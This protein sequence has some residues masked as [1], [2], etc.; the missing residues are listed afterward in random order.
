MFTKTTIV[1]LG[2]FV[3]CEVCTLIVFCYQRTVRKLA[4]RLQIA[5]SKL[6]FCYPKWMLTMYKGT[7]LKFGIILALFII[8]WRCALVSLGI[9]ALFFFLSCVIIVPDGGNLIRIRREVKRCGRGTI[10]ITTYQAL[11]TE[12]EKGIVAT[13]G[14][15]AKIDAEEQKQ[16][17]WGLPSRQQENFEWADGKTKVI[18]K[19]KPQDAIVRTWEN[20]PA[21]IKGAV[22]AIGLVFGG[23]LLLVGVTTGEITPLLVL[24]LLFIFAWLGFWIYQILRGKNWTRVFAI[25]IVLQVIVSSIN[26]SKGGAFDFSST[27]GGACIALVIAALLFCP[28]ANQWFV[29]WPQGWSYWP[30]LLVIAQIVTVLINQ[31]TFERSDANSIDES[32]VSQE[33]RHKRRTKHADTD[34]NINYANAP[35]EK[36]QE[37]AQDGIA[38]AQVNL[39]LRYA[40]GRGG[41]EKDRSTSFKWYL[42]AADQGNT[43][44]M[45]RVVE[46]YRYGIGVKQDVDKAV[47]WGRR[48]AKMGNTSSLSSLALALLQGEHGIPKNISLSLK[49]FEI[50][51]ENGDEVSALLLGC[52]ASSNHDSVAARKW[53]GLAAEAGN[54]SSM[55]ELGKMYHDGVGGIKN[56]TQAATWYYKAANKGNL[57]A[58]CLLGGCYMLGDGVD[59]DEEEGV[60][61]LQEAARK[62]YGPAKEVLQKLGRSW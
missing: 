31:S 1:L 50:C 43:N 42:M 21:S 12:I 30:V 56:T 9:F 51:A 59:I 34:T 10:G 44:A 8:E 23:M 11:M 13:G 5:Q 22:I 38:D 20:A 55:L 6:V 49:C 35:I 58:M 61:W 57:E 27:V 15:L 53:Y 18:D 14:D 62:D 47:Q 28:G 17:E 16:T 29:S 3:A 41:V 37:D 46:R 39:G 7:F 60:A 24:V 2:L 25:V 36:V 4:M 48:L 26:I 52:R 33:T 54:V 19:I 32:T 40:T 45:E